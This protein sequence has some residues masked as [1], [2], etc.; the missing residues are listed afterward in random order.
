MELSLIYIIFLENKWQTKHV[1]KTKHLSMCL[2]KF[3]RKQH[4]FAEFYM[5]GP[6]TDSGKN[7]SNIMT[8]F[9]D[10]QKD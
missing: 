10:Y 3:Y 8:G 6:S 7:M 1:R 5:A 9:G 2:R 4:R